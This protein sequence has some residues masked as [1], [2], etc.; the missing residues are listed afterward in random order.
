M[1][2]NVINKKMVHDGDNKI[3]SMAFSKNFAVLATAAT[4]GSK[5]LNPETLEIMRFFKQ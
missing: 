2:S 1:I 4:N 5:I 3:N